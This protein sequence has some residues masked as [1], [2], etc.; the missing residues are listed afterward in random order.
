MRKLKLQMQISVDGYNAAGPNDEQKWV[1]WDL[2]SIRPHV[3]GLL[4][5]GDT[6]LIGR[7]LAVDFIPF[8]LNTAQDTAHPM[9]DFATRIVAAQKIV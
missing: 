1:T 7:K 6:L 8:W 9:H 4:D 2:D 3:V 5:S